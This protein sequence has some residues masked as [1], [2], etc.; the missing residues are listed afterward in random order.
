[1]TYCENC[2]NKVS[3]TAKFCST[4]GFSISI[5]HSGT[6]LKKEN[7][8]TLEGIQLNNNQST[9]E[10]NDEN[11]ELKI[12]ESGQGKEDTA[13]IEKITFVLGLMLIYCNVLIAFLLIWDLE[14][15]I[16]WLLDL[17][18]G[19]ATLL[20]LI[21]IF[22]IVFGYVERK[23][24]ISMITFITSAMF[25]IN[26][27]MDRPLLKLYSIDM[28]GLEFFYT[29]DIIG[30]VLSIFII[31]ANLISG[32]NAIIAVINP[33]KTKYKEEVSPIKFMDRGGIR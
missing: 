14:T 12:K 8:S 29:L 27:Q 32:Y 20:I 16:D 30:F 24:A 21:I 1:M 33:N 9:I 4:C 23:R 22:N 26:L 6:D 13:T 19:S 15:I 31:A 2:G 17:N 7:T 5:E 25:F 10:S 11:L 3:D 28:L 18:N